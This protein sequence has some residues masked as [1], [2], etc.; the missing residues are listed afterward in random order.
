LKP[1]TPGFVGEKLKEARLARGLNGTALSDLLQVSRQSISKYENDLQAPSP[2]VMEEICN[3][4]KLPID[5]FVSKRK[6]T[7][8][9]SSPIFYRSLSSATKAERLRAE[10]RYIWLQDIYSYLFRFVDFPRLNLP[11]YKLPNDPFLISNELIEEIA[12]KLRMFWGLGLGPIS[13]ITHL[14]ENNG[15]IVGSYDLDTATLEGFSQFQFDKPVIILGIDKCSAARNRF[16]LAHE[17]GHLILHKNISINTLN[18]SKYFKHIEKQAHRFAGAFLFPE[19]AFYE[20]MINSSIDFFRLKKSTWKISIGAQIFRARD[21]GMLSEEDSKKIWRSY[22][23]QGMKTK[24]PLD[25]LLEIEKP[26]L[27]RNGFHLIIDNNIRT[28]ASIAFEL[29]LNPKDIETL[30]GL[31]LGYLQNEVISFPV[32]KEILPIESPAFERGE[33][34]HLFRK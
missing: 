8:D 17:L 32:R 5:F 3:I 24:E 14:V 6:R 1:T 25:D 15:I 11:D 12:I 4:L 7:I 9:Y 10:S 13:N 34:V 33:V 28:R 29:K 23:R 27:L 2:E 31:E 22:S 18:T 20:E 26:I 21:L 30:S 19:P 16:T